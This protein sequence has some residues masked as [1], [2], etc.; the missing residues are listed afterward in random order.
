VRFSELFDEFIEFDVVLSEVPT[1]DGI[2]KDVIVN[3]KMF[4]DFE[5]NRTFWT[6]SNGLEMQQ[7]WID[8][9]QEFVRGPEKM[10]ISNHYFPVNSAIAIRD[11][12]KNRQVTIMNDRTQGGSAELVKS[13]IELM[14]HRRLV[15]HDLF[16]VNQAL[17]ETDKADIG[18][19]IQANYYMQIF[20]TS[21]G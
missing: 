16:G 18:I 2:G 5:A 20:D 10:N 12:K 13:S 7:R 17:N 4:D 19:G 9:H 21:K 6:D 15:Y 8:H 11:G 3:W 14:H 1:N